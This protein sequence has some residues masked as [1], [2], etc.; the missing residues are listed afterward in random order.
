MNDELIEFLT[1]HFAKHGWE[2]NLSDGK[3]VPTEKDFRVALDEA[4]RVL[5]SDNGEQRYEI[6]TPL[7]I[8]RLVI[9]KNKTSFDIYVMAGTSHI[10]KENQ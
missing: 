8:G 9:I 1:A 6:G 3:R 5:Y 2:W 10:K 7:Q 4:E